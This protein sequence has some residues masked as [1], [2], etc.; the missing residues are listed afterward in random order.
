MKIRERIENF[1]SAGKPVFIPYITG[2][3]P[4]RTST[5]EVI[6]GLDRLGAAV[7]ELGIPFSDPIAD[8]SVNM[9]VMELALADD[10]SLR[11][12]LEIV[13]EVRRRGC[14]IPI[15]IFSYLNPILAMGYETFAA[16]AV[17]AGVQGVL[18]VDLPIEIADEVWDTFTGAGLE[19]IFLSSPTTA[20]QR[21]EQLKKYPPAFLYY[22]SRLGVTGASSQLSDTLK[23]EVDH[24]R[25]LTENAFPICVGFGIS[26][27]EHVRDVLTF[28]EG[29]IVGSALMKELLI[30]P[31]DAGVQAVLDK[32]QELM[33]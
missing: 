12:C 7:I 3:V 17:D 25:E 21:L 33:S 19:M 14:D 15:V 18:C 2:G 10:V 23:D 8:G 24:V 9:A 27:R 28:A 29:A 30:H 32:A 11:D 16:A 5:V 4:S 1:K 31:G 20:G 6:L 22:V 13:R 26:T